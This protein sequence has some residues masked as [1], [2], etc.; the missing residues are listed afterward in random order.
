MDEIPEELV[1]NFYQT[2]ICYVP[3]S[4]WMMA[5]EGAKRVELSGKDD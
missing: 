1:V 5:K 3:V 4:D 2:G